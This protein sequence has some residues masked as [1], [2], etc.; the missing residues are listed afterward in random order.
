MKCAIPKPAGGMRVCALLVLAAV[1][2]HSSG[3]AALLWTAPSI[4]GAALLITWAAESAQFFIAQG[5]ALAILAWLQTLPEFAVEAVLASQQKVDLLL[6]GLTGALRLL[7]G[8]GWPMIYLTAA[9][10]YRRRE[11]K[12]LRAVRLSEEQSV[13]VVGLLVC[14][15]YAVVIWWKGSLN[16]VDAI[17]LTGIYVLYLVVLSK[18]PPQH[19]E[20]IDELERIPRAIVLAPRAVRVSAIS[21]LFLAGGSVIYFVAE[22]FL[23]SLQAVS[24]LI[25]VST[26]NFIQWVAPFVSE[27]PEGISAFNW[28]RT[29]ERA[30]MALR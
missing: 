8:L 13:E 14:L 18:L 19:A 7:T 23:N 2:I 6:A 24:A 3:P 29:V 21:L 12:P 17:V 15:A 20:G 25:G 1:P 26:F 28:A 27:F 22:P 16:L 5:F 9:M 4:L 30:S 11:G 10:A